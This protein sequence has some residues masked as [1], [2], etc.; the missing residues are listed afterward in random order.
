ML[1]YIT[2]HICDEKENN[3]KNKFL[4]I[5][6]VRLSHN[7]NLESESDFLCSGMGLR[8]W[9]RLLISVAGGSHPFI[10]K[11]GFERKVKQDLRTVSKMFLS[12]IHRKLFEKSH[13]IGIFCSLLSQISV[14]VQ[15]KFNSR[16]IRN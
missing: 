2:L 5:Q 3:K 9:P 13:E 8:E 15:L 6:F 10:P 16:C 7:S 4:L 11:Q 1:H 14:K 12:T